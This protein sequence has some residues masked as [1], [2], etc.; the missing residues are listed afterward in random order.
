M[1]KKQAVIIVTLLVLIVCLGMVAT[2]VNSPLIGKNADKIGEKTAISFKNNE[3]SK[4]SNTNYFVES[5]M[6]KQEETAKVLQQLKT[7][8]DDQNVS[9]EQKN[10]V[11]EEFSTIS[12]NSDKENKVE[13]ALKGKGFEDAVCMIENNNKVKVI[14]KSQKL[15][16]KQIKEIQNIVM[17]ITGLNNVEI[18]NKQ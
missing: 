9:K 6:L 5:R 10:K 3:K 1:N 14:V 7:V 11:I 12:T 4:S 8:I 16:E 13:I 18:E 2:K 17:S 15:S